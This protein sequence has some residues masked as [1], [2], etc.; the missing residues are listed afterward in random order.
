MFE[1]LLKDALRGERRDGPQS[2]AASLKLLNGDEAHA[3]LMSS[4]QAQKPGRV[5]ACVCVCVFKSL[6]RKRST[7]LIISE[8]S[9]IRLL[10]N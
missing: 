8:H 4:S 10:G 9:A 5:C 3:P 2:G 7:A 6:L 1:G